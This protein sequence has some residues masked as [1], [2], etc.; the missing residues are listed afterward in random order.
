MPPPLYT[1][2]TRQPSDLGRGLGTH[3]GTTGSVTLQDPS[4]LKTTTLWGTS[5]AAVVTRDIHSASTT[6]PSW[7]QVS[8][9][10]SSCSLVQ[11]NSSPSERL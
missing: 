10:R 11:Q 5:R 2:A 4:G 1:S 6:L 8:R 9:L 3:P 7:I